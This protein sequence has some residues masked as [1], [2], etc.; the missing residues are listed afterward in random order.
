MAEIS[1]ID[2]KLPS[3]FNLWLFWT[4]NHLFHFIIDSGVMKLLRT[5]IFYSSDIVCLKYFFIN[6]ILEK[7]VSAEA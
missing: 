6:F 5:R 1:K 2:K 4:N 7:D 3:T